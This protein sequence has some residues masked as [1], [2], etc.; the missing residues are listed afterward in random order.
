[1]ISSVMSLCLYMVFDGTQTCLGASSDDMEDF[2][3]L[4]FSTERNEAPCSIHFIVRADV[5]QD[6]H[7]FVRLWIGFEGKHNPTI[8]FDPARPQTF[9]LSPKLVRLQQRIKC[10]LG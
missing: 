8:I 3:W 7:I 4:G 9:E 6:N 5:N 10:I 1:M 2:H